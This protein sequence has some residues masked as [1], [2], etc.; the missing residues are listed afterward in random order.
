M[1]TAVLF[2]YLGLQTLKIALLAIG[3]GI[4]TIVI[5]MGTLFIFNCFRW[6]DLDD[7]P[8]HLKWKQRQRLAD[9]LRQAEPDIVL[10]TIRDGVKDAAVFANEIKAAFEDAGWAMDI[11]NRHPTW[12]LEH[13]YGL[14]VYGHSLQG[15]E[16]SI[17][18]ER[19]VAALQKA[20]VPIHV[21]RRTNLGGC[22]AEIVVGRYDGHLHVGDLN[23]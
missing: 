21:D 2:Y 23:V 3:C 10:V 12:D 4:A 9:A 1:L 13:E 5:S 11:E 22:H 6:Q 18:R 16:A 7:P 14:W 8:R 17:A 20:K 15:P 19:I